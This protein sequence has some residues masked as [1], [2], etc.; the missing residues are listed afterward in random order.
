MSWLT[1]FLGFDLIIESKDSEIVNLQIQL[2][3]QNEVIAA[4]DQEIQRLTN[5]ILTEH[6][7]IQRE[8]EAKVSE[9]K[10]QIV[11]RR[12]SF[13]A[14]RDKYERADAAMAEKISQEHTEVLTEYWTKKNQQAMQE[15]A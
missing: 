5:L 11:N 14:L 3:H 6:G 7:V 1:K 2:Q 12:G 4:K 13:K 9:S 8:G 10:P 15:K